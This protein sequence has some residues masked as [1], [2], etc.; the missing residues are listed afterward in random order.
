MLRARSPIVS[1][2]E[3]LGAL[4][5]DLTNELRQ[6]IAQ[7]AEPLHCG[8]GIGLPLVNRDMTPATAHVVALNRRVT[9]TGAVV[10]IFV[11]S[12]GT[13]SP[14]DLR[15]VGRM[16]RLAPAESRLLRYLV[17]GKTLAEA[18]ASL[19]VTEATAK[20]HHSEILSKAGV[21]QW[22]ELIIMIGRLI[23]PICLAQSS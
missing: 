20:A 21:S 13:S 8:S 17:A 18:A 14:V 11:T 3:Q 4:R 15:T 19:G 2:G 12:A 23:P 5:A 16:F 10:A 1:L 9:S 7:A 6:A 22:T